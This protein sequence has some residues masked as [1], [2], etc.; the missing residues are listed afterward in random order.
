MVH[1]CNGNSKKN[2]IGIIGLEN[3]ALIL[4]MEMQCNLPLILLVG[5]RMASHELL[6]F[7]SATTFDCG[8]AVRAFMFSVLRLL[9]N[10]TGVL[11]LLLPPLVL[12]LLL[13]SNNFVSSMG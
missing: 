13:H 8:V 3:R 7:S 9:D 6:L 10:D 11:V 1:I 12:I 5:V 4:K 2:Q